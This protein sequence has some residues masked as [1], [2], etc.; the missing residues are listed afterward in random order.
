MQAKWYL[1]DNSITACQQRPT[2]ATTTVEQ[3][4]QIMR[5]FVAERDWQQFH[6]PKNLSMSLAIE[7]AE[8]MKH[9]QW[10]D[11][12]ASRQ[13]KD[14]PAK[15]AAVG[16]ELAD[17][18]CYALALSNELGRDLSDTVRAKMQKKAAKHPAAEFK[19]RY[20]RDDI[21]YPTWEQTSWSAH[22]HRSGS[23]DQEVCRHGISAYTPCAG[24]GPRG[25]ALCPSW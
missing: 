15:L 9:F 25:S 7:A 1:A 8:L 16:E 21:K 3:L 14:D 20:G 11:V 4:K 18:L 22:L 19:G 12:P 10:I 17:V 24:A 23:A 5:T 2:D 13:M 6:S